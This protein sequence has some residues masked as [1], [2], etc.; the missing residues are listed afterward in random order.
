MVAGNRQRGQGGHHAKDQ[1]YTNNF[2]P[3]CKNS[4]SWN[5]VTFSRDFTNDQLLFQCTLATCTKK[6]EIWGR[7]CE[8]VT[9][10]QQY[11][12]FGSG[13]SQK[14]ADTLRNSSGWQGRQSSRNRCRYICVYIHWKRRTRNSGNGRQGRQSSRNR[15]PRFQCRY[16]Y[17]DRYSK[18]RERNSENRAD[19]LQKRT[20]LTESLL[21]T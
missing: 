12:T 13:N 10:W 15:T 19:K 1:D 4:K 8:V 5:D 20:Q 2:H 11:R 16:I 21:I 3:L 9:G 6:Y 14:R 17:V 18:C 7:L